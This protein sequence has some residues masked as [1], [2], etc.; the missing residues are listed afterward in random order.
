MPW[1]LAYDI[2]EDNLREKTANKLLELGLLRI[3]QSVFIGNPSE[4][5]L[6]ILKSWLKKNINKTEKTKDFVLLLPCTQLQLEQATHYG[7]TPINWAMIIAP[8]NTLII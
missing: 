6:K 1:T 5:V 2:S 8:P 4:T 7:K 3:Q